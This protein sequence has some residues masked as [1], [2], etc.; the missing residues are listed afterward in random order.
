MWQELLRNKYIKDKTLESCDKKLTYSYCL[1]SL[2]NVK[3]SFMDFLSFEVK[4]GTETR[5]WEDKWLGNKPLKDIFP[6]LFNIVRRKQD[7]MAQIL[8]SPPLNISFH[9]NLVGANLSNWHRIIASLQHV[10]LMEERD[11]LFGG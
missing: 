3:Y 6:A 8:N 4:D 2:M 7:S 11:V 9:R 5:F 10:N 1:K